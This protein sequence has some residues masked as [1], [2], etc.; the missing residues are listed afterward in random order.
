MIANHPFYAYPSTPRS[1]AAAP[2]LS[3][4]TTGLPP[5]TASASNASP[6]APS[7]MQ[8][9]LSARGTTPPVSMLS[10]SF[11]NLSMSPVSTSS[12]AMAAYAA[13][14]AASAAAVRDSSTAPCSPSSVSS[15][16]LAP[17]AT[18]SS[19]AS[20]FMV[21]S[22]T[23]AAVAYDEQHR[24]S[25]VSSSEMDDAAELADRLGASLALARQWIV[26]TA[27]HPHTRRLLSAYRPVTGIM[28]TVVGTMLRRD[29][30]TE[31]TSLV[32]L[33][34]AFSPADDAWQRAVRS[35]TGYYSSLLV[36]A[37]PTTTSPHVPAALAAYPA[38][39]LDP[40]GL[41]EM[42]TPAI[43]ASLL[44]AIVSANGSSSAPDATTAARAHGL[45]HTLLASV[46]G[47][48]RSS[49]HGGGNRHS[50]WIPAG[51]LDLAWPAPYGHPSQ[52]NQQQEMP[53]A[54]A[55]SLAAAECAPALE[56][57]LA[58]AEYVQR[59][60]AP[61]GTASAIAAVVAGVTVRHTAA[62]DARAAARRD[63]RVK[64]DGGAWDPAAAWA[65]EGI[66]SPVV[67]AASIRSLGGTGSDLDDD[68]NAAD[69]D[70]N[71]TEAALAAVVRAAQI[72]QC[73]AAVSPAAAAAVAR[74]AIDDWELNYGL[75]PHFPSASSSWTSLASAAAASSAPSG[76]TTTTL[77]A[78]LA[79][80][81]A[82]LMPAAAAIA[83]HRLGRA[84]RARSARAR[85]VAAAS[86]ARRQAVRGPDRRAVGGF[87]AGMPDDPVRQ[88]VSV[89]ACAVAAMVAT[90]SAV[91]DEQRAAASSVGSYSTSP[92]MMQQMMHHQRYQQQ[93]G[94]QDDADDEDDDDAGQVWDPLA[95]V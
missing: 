81:A 9:K 27:V 42:S 84:A 54:T 44:R 86:L 28:R 37:P 76:T 93:R 3:I 59:G 23:P 57:A 5:S 62:R 12:S 36:S 70:D 50:A 40:R 41:G 26:G 38:L 14:A 48:V 34:T 24:S 58:L 21:G 94:D 85:A 8:L 64:V 49:H 79:T 19:R 95:L 45:A 7:P 46:R 90:V 25:L 60:W 2:P 87:A 4:F 31:L 17:M 16:S 47:G 72:A 83:G 77:A 67:R 73:L 55:D 69:D 39:M 75:A 6:I 1:A 91:A 52:Q 92:S 71:E 15:L 89:V 78:A 13:S 53:A 66:A 30:F 63:A 43:A 10:A 68:A 80:H 32:A 35:V 22:P 88:E 65:D 82:A 61:A 33:S 18:R 29:A 20:S 74:A 51:S 56:C 11:Q